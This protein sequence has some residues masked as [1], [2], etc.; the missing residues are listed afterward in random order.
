M[1]ELTLPTCTRCRKTKKKCDRGLPGCAPCVA[2]GVDCSFTDPSSSRVV[3]RKY[4]SRLH[5]RCQELEKNLQTLQ[6]SAT[7]EADVDTGFDIDPQLTPLYV[8]TG[9]SIVYLGPGNAASLGT[10]FSTNLS[11]HTWETR[12]AGKGSGH[13]RLRDTSGV[14]EEGLGSNII[15]QSLIW[16]LIRSHFL[17]VVNRL[18]PVIDPQQLKL[19]VKTDRLPHSCQL[20]VVS[21]AAIAA[22]HQARSH[23]RL[24]VASIALRQ[25]AD[26]L[27]PRVLQD[28]N[29]NSLQALALLILYEVVDPSR[30]QIWRL[31]GF[32]G[33]MITRLRW[34]LPCDEEPN[35]MHTE[36][37][38]TGT[39][40][41]RYPASWRRR[42]LKVIYR[43]ERSV[44]RTLRRDALLPSMNACFPT[45][46]EGSA[47]A[48]FQ[49]QMLDEI[50]RN[51]RGRACPVTPD[52]VHFINNNLGDGESDGPLLL[53]LAPVAHHACEACVEYAH[54]WTPEIC[55]AAM[56][57]LDMMFEAYRRGEII[58]HWISTVEVFTAASAF[59][60][61]A[62]QLSR[63]GYGLSAEWYRGVLNAC[64]M[65]A[66]FSE[67]WPDG[68][69]FR[70]TFH[71]LSEQWLS[72]TWQT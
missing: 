4:V 62:T 69:A 23:S 14:R 26:R 44:C 33:R 5:D 39:S 28:H 68:K 54:Q 22:A 48:L 53:T 70:D 9:S 13:Q 51:S 17:P 41:H 36:S 6:R 16:D 64:T 52:L 12:A 31:L 19:D 58:S 65:L 40:G 38:D 25:W 34:H 10:F 66:A 60:A 2:A 67:V 1:A 27:L 61:T 15:E 46:V 49:E 43:W 57:Q 3:T 32:A 11:S 50:L 71:T 8:T 7:V 35:L 30:K 29:D 47:H 59:L 37:L 42:L 20:F 45:L 56:L 63:T 72:Q 18:C 55:K 24:N 21:A